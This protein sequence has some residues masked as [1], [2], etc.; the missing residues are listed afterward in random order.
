VGV[1]RVLRD[2]RESR[3]EKAERGKLG[4][5][6]RSVV[7]PAEGRVLEVGAGMGFSLPLFTRARTVAATD[8]DVEALRRARKRVASAPTKAWLLA[9]DAQYLPFRPHVFDAAV[10]AL[11][12]C[13]V[14]DPDRAFTELQR[15]VRPGG[16]VRFL[17][18]VRMR[19]P[20]LAKLQDWITPLN[21]IVAGGCHQNRATVETARRSGLRVSAVRP[22]LKGYIVE[23]DAVVPETG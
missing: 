20:I 10:G 12:F 8:P 14:P 4:R 21:K 6:R 15:V 13:S 11:V 1:R 16:A 18:H 17:E 23:V 7:A 19:N 2:F 5:W 3:Q 22:H 9:A